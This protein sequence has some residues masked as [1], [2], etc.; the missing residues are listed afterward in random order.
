MASDL[1]VQGELITI[2]LNKA[3]GYQN[4]TH[5]VVHFTKWKSRSWAARHS[6]WKTMI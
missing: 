3:T 4:N 2:P 6:N 5:V 1:M